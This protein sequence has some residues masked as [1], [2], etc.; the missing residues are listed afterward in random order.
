LISVVTSGHQTEGHS[1]R[2][3][4]HGRIEH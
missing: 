3:S 4:G 1:Y 2:K